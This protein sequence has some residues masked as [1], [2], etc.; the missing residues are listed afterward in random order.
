MIRGEDNDR[1]LLCRVGSR[2]A[3][4]DV[5]DVWETMPAAHRTANG[6]AGIY[7]WPRHRQRV[8]DTGGR[9]RP[10]TRFICIVLHTV[11]LTVSRTIHFAQAGRP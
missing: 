9:R 8:S 2:I 6:S 11:G 4:L 5:R 10:A 7:T 1:F 3:A